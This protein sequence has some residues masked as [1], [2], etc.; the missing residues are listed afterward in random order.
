MAEPLSIT[1]GIGS[2]LSFLGHAYNYARNVSGAS[3]QA[4]QVAEQLLTTKSLLTTL[5]HTLSSE[6]RPR[7][8]IE[9]WAPTTGKIVASVRT[10]IQ[11]LGNKIGSDDGLR[12][13]ST[14]NLSAWDKMTWPL[15]RE[16]TLALQHQLSSYIQMLSMVQ[17]A[18]AQYVG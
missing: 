18:F 16:E 6:P 4:Q 15:E 13:S 9:L 5:K 14:V 11:Q 2:T 3:S 17:N 1:A 7:H 12:S 8:F 10:T